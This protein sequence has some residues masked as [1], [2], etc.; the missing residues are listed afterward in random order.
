MTDQSLNNYK[1]IDFEKSTKNGFDIEENSNK[2]STS[3]HT[4]YDRVNDKENTNISE[5]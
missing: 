2:V 4:A 3:F 1:S 5:G